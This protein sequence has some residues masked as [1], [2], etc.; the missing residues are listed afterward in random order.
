MKKVRI[1]LL[2]ALIGLGIVTLSVF[3]NGNRLGYDPGLN[4]EALPEK[5]DMEL[6]GVNFTEVNKGRQDW[7]MVAATMQYFK[8]TELMVFNQVKV[9]FYHKDGPMHVEGAQG[10]YYKNLKKLRLRGEI[11]AW[12]S[13]GN[14]LTTK[15]LGYNAEAKILTAPGRFQLRG[16]KV[17]LDGLGLVVKTEDQTMQ[18]RKKADLLV[19]SKQNIL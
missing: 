12:D 8:A 3:M 10:F 16:P 11:K 5:V 13:K 19:K 17:D 2:T 7:T 9:T 14:V 4:S 15:E 6:T 1:L 18:V